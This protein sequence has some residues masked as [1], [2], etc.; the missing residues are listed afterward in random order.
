VT[1]PSPNDETTKADTEAGVRTE[2]D[3]ATTREEI[4]P[5]IGA[6]LGAYRIDEVLGRGGMGVVYRAFDVR[7]DRAVAVKVMRFA[8]P[9]ARARFQREARAQAGL[10]HR[11]VVP[12]HVVGEHAGL[13]FI[14]MDLVNGQ[15]LKQALDR[16]GTLTERRAL[17][18]AD[19]IAAALEAAKARGLIHRDVKPSNVL[20]ES[21]GHVLLTDFGLAKQVLENEDESDMTDEAPVSAMPRSLTQTGSVLGTPAYL[22]PEQARGEKVDHRADMYALGVTLYE[23]IAGERPARGAIVSLD[24]ATPATRALL[25][26]LLATRADDRFATYALLRAAIT[27]ARGVRT[28]AAPLVSRIFALLVDYFAFG[29]VT[30]VLIAVA[31]VTAQLVLGSDVLKPPIKLLSWPIAAVLVGI[32]EA[33]FG[34]TL[35]KKLQRLRTIDARD[36]GRP[37]LG[38]CVARSV[39]KMSPLYALSL[40]MVVTLPK[41]L[42]GFWLLGVGFL[43]GLPALGR[44]RTTLHDRICRTR[45]I[46]VVEDDVE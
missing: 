14:V 29:V 43:L 36:S 20:L 30:S 1:A 23:L 11:N 40:G 18:V 22:A 31:M 15:T 9:Q 46:L 35:G 26:T 5:L 28:V 33:R 8:N 7:L 24:N 12:V 21:D 39:V 38:R 32:A 17:E 25:R 45:V 44:T 19:A 13:S 41:A 2:E 3:L 4:D 27:R 6:L 37:S 34:T 10:G 16:D 42:P